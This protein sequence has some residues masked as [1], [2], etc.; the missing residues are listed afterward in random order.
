MGADEEGT[1]QR[2]RANLR[3]LVDP[4][5]KQHRGRIVKNTGDGMLAEFPS[6]VDAVRCA[7]EMQRGMADRNVEALEDKRI[8]FRIGTNLGDVIAEQD[9]IYGDGV[10]VAIDVAMTRA[11]LDAGAN[12]NLA[13]LT[14]FTPLHHAAEAGAK[15]AAT[16]LITNGANL[17]LRNRYGETPEQTAVRT[18]HTEVAEILRRAM[19][20]K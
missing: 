18:H 17:T 2:L 19:T 16:L 6:V 7:V 12:I 10:N 3:D 9:D 11:L 1:H 5:I 4:K 14:G 8:A 20:P 13:N 15:E